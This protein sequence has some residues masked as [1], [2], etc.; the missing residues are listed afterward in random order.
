MDGGVERVILNLAAEWRDVGAEVVVATLSTQEKFFYSIPA[1]I[2]SVSL[3]ISG[4]SSSILSLLRNNILPLVKIRRLLRREKPDVVIAMRPISAVG[5]AL[6]RTGDEIAI[7]AEHVHPPTVLLGWMWSFV[8]RYAYARLDAV[9]AL[10]PQS[11]AWLRENTR[12]RKVVTIPNWTSLPLLDNEPNIAPE[13]IV[14]A[15]RKLLLAAG[16]FDPQKRFDRLLDAF[17]QIAQR[18]PDWCLVILGEDL[19]K[20]GKLREELELQVDRL[21]LRQQV[22]LPGFVGNIAD[23]YK[24][25]DAFALTSDFEG[26]AMVLI[27]A[28]A[29]GCPAISVDCPAGP[30]DIVNNDENG[31]LVPLNDFDALVSGLDKL[32]SD[33]TLRERLASSAVEVLDT[34]SPT[35]INVA[36]QDL[37]G[38]LRQEGNAQKTQT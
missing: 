31:L 6:A 21:D 29:H 20:K 10:V 17:A 24:A 14:P 18:H 37:F 34:Y 12:A 16:R 26:F 19:S 32:L 5:L 4:R 28:M 3:D 1:G 15:G 27:E 2:R 30:G 9:V 13:D 33:D 38:D 23:W 35:R 11:A 25:A 7:G 22:H 36:W 8:R